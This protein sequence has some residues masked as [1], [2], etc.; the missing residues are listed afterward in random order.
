MQCQPLWQHRTYHQ[1][2]GN[3]LRTDVSRQGDFVARQSSSFDVQGGKSFVADIFYAGSEAAQG[4]YQNAD[5]A[6]LHA[7]RS[8]DDAVAGR[9]TEV[10]GKEAHGCARSQYVDGVCCPGF[11]SLHHD[12]GIVAVAQ[13]VRTVFAVAQGVQY[14]GTVADAFRGR[15]RDGGSG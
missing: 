7:C 8:C 13:V 14:E 11:E 9:Y 10:S 1:Q 12:A 4:F 5:G 15:Q 3:I 2:G 6:L